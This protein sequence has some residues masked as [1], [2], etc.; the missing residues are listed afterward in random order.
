VVVLLK[1]GSCITERSINPRA[2]ALERSRTMAES[3]EAQINPAQNRCFGNNCQAGNPDKQRQEQIKK[4][5][6]ISAK[7]RKDA[8]KSLLLLKERHRCNYAGLLKVVERLVDRGDL[9]LCV[10]EVLI[11]KV[12]AQ[13]KK[14]GLFLPDEDLENAKN[15]PVRTRK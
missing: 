12:E 5:F 13:R 2:S 4:A 10:F 8:N 14:N 15:S 11:G 6:E 3:R 7:M 1:N 9:S